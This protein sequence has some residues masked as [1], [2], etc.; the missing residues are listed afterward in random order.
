MTMARTL[1]NDLDKALLAHQAGH[2][3][4]AEK[5]Y[6]KITTIAPSNSNA[7][8]LLGALY[9]Q[10]GNIIQAKECLNRGIKMTPN[11]PQALNTR[12]ILNKETGQIMEA[13]L[14]FRA[15]LILAPD[16]PEVL[17][18]LADTRRLA[19]DLSEA[20]NLN[21]QAIKLAPNLA[22]AYNNRG[23]IE[24]ELGN[25]QKAKTAFQTAL[26]LNANLS[27]AAINLAI[28]LKMLGQTGIALKT[29]VNT[30]KRRPNYA[31]AHNCLGLI[32][33]GLEKNT[34]AKASF[35]KACSIDPNYAD[36]QNNLGNTLSR[37]DKTAEAQNHYNI[38]VRLEP[39]NP[40]FW[41][42]KAASLQAENR[43]DEVIV[44][45]N[46][47][48]NID[49][50]HPDSRWNRGIARLISG[51]LLY[52]FADYEARWLLP[53]F[54]NRSFNSQ[55]WK[56]ENLRDKS[57]LL[58]SEQGFGDTI[59]F[60]RYVTF[61][62][63]QK[64][65]AVYLETHKPLVSLLRAMPEID[66]IF[67]RGEELPKS[68][69]H[70]PLMSLAH[71]FKTTLNTIPKTTPYLKVKETSSY[72]F[73]DNHNYRKNIKIG[74]AWA[75]RKTHKNDQNRSIPLDL[76]VPF[77]QNPNVQFYSL[78]LDRAK[79][80]NGNSAYLIDLSAYLTD[81]A[82]TGSILKNLDLVITVDTALAHLAGSLGVK[83]WVMLP[84]APDWR[85][86]L[87][88]DNTPWYSSITLF[89]QQK[90]NSWESVV[91][92][93]MSALENFHLSKVE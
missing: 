62:T 46:N 67:N 24:Q 55:L 37:L 13:E 33:F 75:G 45:C 38:A 1:K 3:K 61:L 53:E 69:Y 16:F 82:A 92:Q 40:D 6:R 26:D 89:R 12:G 54:N 30:I 44:A 70:I 21:N 31:P 71:R 51:D 79:D 78:Q 35:K 88:N 56:G 60:I 68:D 84:F 4:K 52:G 65:K 83:C 27:D 80:Y 43:V 87:D 10:T 7:W 17:T 47:A 23:A 5:L 14:D 81:F 29:A 25:L 36:A 66:K 74:I 91:N 22:P 19:G 32:Y 57:I 48:L 50:N 15:A 76:C 64:P 59:Q 73:K 2:L 42:N 11:F 86:L 85:W 41:A 28:L 77:L 49:P 9:H 72:S 18:N 93:I 58:H 8:H 63:K 34:A 39:N 90:R 20:E